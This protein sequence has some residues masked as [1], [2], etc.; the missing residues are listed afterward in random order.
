MKDAQKNNKQLKMYS[1]ILFVTMIASIALVWGAAAPQLWA[2]GGN[3]HR[4]RAEEFEEAAAA[5][6]AAA[7]QDGPGVMAF[8]CSLAATLALGAVAVMLFLELKGLGAF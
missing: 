2:S 7:A 4:F 6:A 1:G 3:H 5:P 8:I